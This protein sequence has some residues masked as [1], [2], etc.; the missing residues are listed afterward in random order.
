MSVKYS[1]KKEDKVVVLSGKDGG[2]KGR[3]LKVLPKTGMAVVEGVHFVKRHTRANP[4]KN[5]KGGVVERESPIRISKLMVICPACS[6]PGRVLRK[7]LQDGR[8]VRACRACG[9]EYVK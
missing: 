3:V 1:V 8:H 5:I 2:K 4:Q 9:A 7:V 6:K